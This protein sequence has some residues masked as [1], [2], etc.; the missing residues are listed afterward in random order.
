MYKH[1]SITPQPPEIAPFKVE[2]SHG[3]LGNYYR[4]AFPVTHADIH[5]P[6]P[7]SIGFIGKDANS[8]LALG[9]SKPNVARNF[10]EGKE[11]IQW[12]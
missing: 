8:H 2:Q 12:K 1:L 9:A 10:R 3:F 11:F 4:A 6:D 7:H 5:I